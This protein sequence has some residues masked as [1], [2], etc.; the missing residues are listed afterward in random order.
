M[1]EAM[2][3]R[4]R[5]LTAQLPTFPSLLI[6]S[7]GI[8]AQVSAPPRPHPPARAPRAPSEVFVAAQACARRR[9]R[10]AAAGW[11][12]HSMSGAQCPSATYMRRRGGTCSVRLLCTTAPARRPCP[13]SGGA[14]AVMGMLARR[15]Q[16]RVLA[17]GRI[18]ASPG[19][20]SA[21]GPGAGGAAGGGAVGEKNRHRGPLL[22]GP[23]GVRR[24]ATPP[25]SPSV[26]LEPVVCSQ[27]L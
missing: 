14:R 6:D 24:R 7:D 19:T 10:A 5:F 4:T 16:W 17:A 25:P 18:C 12:W 11:R 21:A 20:V 8:T 26:T 2:R 15:L 3:R 1:L 27:H 23:R 13:C 9:C 22:H